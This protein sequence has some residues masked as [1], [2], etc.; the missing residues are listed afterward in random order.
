MAIKGAKEYKKWK[1]GNPLTRRESMAA[2]CYICNGADESAVDCGGRVS[3]PMY[4]YSLYGEFKTWG[5]IK[6]TVSEENRASLEKARAKA[7]K[8]RKSKGVVK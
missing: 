8:I 5:S 7:M 6:R 1:S 4:E 3:C 2:Q